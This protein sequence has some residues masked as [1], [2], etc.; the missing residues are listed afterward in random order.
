MFAYITIGRTFYIPFLS[1]RCNRTSVN[2]LR[3][4]AIDLLGYSSPDGFLEDVWEGLGGYWHNS[5]AGP[6]GGR[7]PAEH[8]SGPLKFKQSVLQYK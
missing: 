8:P 7:T 2:I 4:E 3:L 1:S 5:E 6:P